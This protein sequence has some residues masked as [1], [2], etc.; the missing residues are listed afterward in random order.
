M[1]SEMFLKL[2]SFN[3]ELHNKIN[4][5]ESYLFNLSCQIEIRESC[6]EFPKDNEAYKNYLLKEKLFYLEQLNKY[7]KLYVNAN[8]SRYI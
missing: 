1:E 8:N 2:S 6:F 7:K 4:E 5:I 3:L